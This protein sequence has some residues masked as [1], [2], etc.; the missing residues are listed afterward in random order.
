MLTYLRGG[1]PIT[2]TEMNA[3]FGAFDGK[4][5]SLLGGR[6]FII[7]WRTFADGGVSATL[8]PE[9]FGQIFFFC[10]GLTAYAQRVPGAVAAGSGVA[11]YSHDEF[12][13][14]AAAAVATEYDTQN[15]IAT[16]ADIPQAAYPAGRT[17]RDAVG[18]FEHSLDV[19]TRMLQGPDDTEPQRYFLREA[20]AVDGTGGAC[21]PTRY[22]D[23][24]LADIIIEGV[25]QVD[26]RGYKKF[27]CFRFHNLQRT[28]CAVL[29][30]GHTINL[31]GYECRSVRR[32]VNHATGEC[33]GYRSSFR[34]FQPFEDPDPRIFW[35]WPTLPSFA[36]GGE[37]TTI[38]ATSAGGMQGNN[39][40]NPCVLYD[41]IKAFTDTRN[42]IFFNRD[43]HELCDMRALV[44][45]YATEFGDP[46]V[47][48]TPLMDLLHHKGR[49]IIA[50]QSKT[51]EDPRAPGSGLMRVTFAEIQFR[52]AATLVADFAAVQIQVQEDGNGNLTFLNIDPDNFVYLVPVGTNLFKNVD[53]T[54]QDNWYVLPTMLDINTAVTIESKIFEN[55]GFSAQPADGSA[56]FQL[57][58]RSN[59]RIAQR[60]IISETNQRTYHTFSDDGVTEHIVTGQPIQSVEEFGFVTARQFA[61]LHRITVEALKGLGYFGNPAL[62]SQSDATVTY[63]TPVLTITPEG[64]V[65]T[66]TERVRADVLPRSTVQFPQPSWYTNNEG[67][68]FVLRQDGATW[69]WEFK[70]AI[71]F[72]KHGFGFGQFG[73]TNAAFF[74]P[75]DGRFSPAAWL[76]DISGPA[77]TDFQTP[78]EHLAE[79]GVKLL[80]SVGARDLG[81]TAGGGRFLMLGTSWNLDGL[82]AFLANY[83]AFPWFQNHSGF[84]ASGNSDVPRTIGPARLLSLPLAAEHYNAFAQAVN[85]LKT[86]R[87]LDWKCLRIPHG[88][89][90]FSFDVESQFGTLDFYPWRTGFFRQGSGVGNVVAL[91]APLNAFIT[92]TKRG[93][94][95]QSDPTQD[96]AADAFLQSLGIPVQIS[97]PLIDAFQDAWNVNQ[98]GE[99]VQRGVTI[100]GTP[101]GGDAIT[102]RDDYGAI[103]W[104]T[105]EAFRA[106]CETMG[107]PFA[108]A[109]VFYPLKLTTFALPEQYDPEIGGG[110]RTQI[111]FK[112]DEDADFKYAAG[113]EPFGFPSGSLHGYDLNVLSTVPE[114]G[115]D[116]YAWL[117]GARRWFACQVVGGVSQSFYVVPESGWGKE[118]SAP[119]TPVESMPWRYIGKAGDPR[120][121][122][123]AA[124]YTLLRPDPDHAERVLFDPVQLLKTF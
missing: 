32:T 26:L 118:A 120:I 46:G 92:T 30:D 42:Y 51:E 31:S 88:T 62:A 80:R 96:P 17:K 41:F 121:V 8:P 87:L 45:L 7:A 29:L 98:A 78:I 66:F 65:L 52:G 69:A 5:N 50:R 71:R 79:D 4:M 106:W 47:D 55:S 74:P 2:P 76:Y 40:S 109:D 1:E 83:S 36:G 124:G 39:L 61:G 123:A 49:I 68:R 93:G 122:T 99:A 77:G 3:L 56:P 16:I 67:S 20:R 114:G 110:N 108:T 94:I 104:V 25:S 97:T 6:S 72:R 117:I 21:S 22:M 53:R 75:H 102:L 60:R 112:L 13:T 23:L 44:S 35:F 59:Y 105:I 101:E 58:D 43:V 64:L 115:E 48:T 38:P 91:P 24:A 28:N 103:H 14:A 100:V 54:G 15:R 111:A 85:Q 113:L 63:S 73:K 19:H 11:P 37:L 82:G 34:Y 95:R 27:A 12:T 9:L 86:G 116:Y 33:T 89:R 119:G 84:L 90:V 81:T 57:S 107:F 70:H 10:A 18:L